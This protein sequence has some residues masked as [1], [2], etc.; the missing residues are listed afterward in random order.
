MTLGV[1]AFYLGTFPRLGGSLD[2]SSGVSNALHQV[3]GWMW[4]VVDVV[5]DML[6]RKFNRVVLGLRW[7]A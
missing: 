5:P 2:S 7:L 4:N 6:L 3:G 1:V